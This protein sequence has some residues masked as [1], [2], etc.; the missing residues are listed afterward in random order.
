[1]VIELERE[2]EPLTR[3]FTVVMEEESPTVRALGRLITYPAYVDD[4]IPARPAQKAGIELGDM[5]REINGEPVDDFNELL[6]L[7]SS[8][9]GEPL[10]M[11][12]ERDGEMIGMTITPVASADDPSIGQIGIFPGNPEKLIE[13]MSVGEALVT[14]PVFIAQYTMRYVNH[15]KMLGGRLVQGDI[16]KVREDLGGP[17]AIA[18]MA[19]I[20]ANQGVERFLRFLIMLNIA[21]AVMNIL[22]LPI[23]D[24]GHIV[25][26]TWEAI[27]G[28]PIPPKVLVPVLNGAVIVLLGFVVLIT[29]SDLFKIFG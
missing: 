18:H 27:F 4:V 19:G 28:K 29:V 7:V 24:G 1:V 25:M 21:L 5:I 12:I 2:G 10:D 15:L 11:L 3:E 16:A 26:A 13:K 22:P 20:M 23:L 14:S 9:P 6:Y 8:S 17:V